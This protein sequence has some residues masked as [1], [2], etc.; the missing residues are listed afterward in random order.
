MR[1]DSLNCMCGS[2]ADNHGVPASPAQW[3][4]PDAMVWQFTRFRVMPS[5]ERAVFAARSASLRACWDAGLPLRGGFLLR[6]A[7]QEWLD[8][9]VWTA[10]AGGE[11]A[12]LT[13]AA[14]RPAFFEEVDELLGEESATVVATEFPVT[15]PPAEG[16]DNRDPPDPCAGQAGQAPP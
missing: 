16:G 14:T 3:S 10:P 2:P 15:T 1:Q 11:T 13:P 12:T 8:V 9:T 5:R 4:G 6:L 7:D